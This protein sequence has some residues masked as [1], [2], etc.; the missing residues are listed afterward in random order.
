MIVP[1]NFKFLSFYVTVACSLSAAGIESYLR[2]VW[3]RQLFSYF[4][5]S[6][7]W[8][9]H[10][11]FSV[12]VLHKL[13]LFFSRPKSLTTDHNSGFWWLSKLCKHSSSVRFSVERWQCQTK[14]FE[15]SQPIL[16]DGFLYSVAIRVIPRWNFCCADHQV[17]YCA[18][19][20]FTVSDSKLLWYQL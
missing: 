19:P 15:P 7:H 1:I 11:E 13:R 6:L 5:V 12:D 2:V 18:S 8:L 3:V 17:E 9:T 14:F 16:L 20:L 10:Y 4:F